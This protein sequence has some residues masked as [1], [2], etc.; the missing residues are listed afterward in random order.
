MPLKDMPD[1]RQ[2]QRSA[3]GYE[4]EEEDD[5]CEMLLIHELVAQAGAATRE[6][7]I[8]ELD[9]ELAQRRGYAFDEKTVQG[10]YGGV[11]A[12]VSRFHVRGALIEPECW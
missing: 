7:T 2:E 1:G 11:S 12:Y 6:A 9:V 3:C 5:D 4:A 8:G 10:A